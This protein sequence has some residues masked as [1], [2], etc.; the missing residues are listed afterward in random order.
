MEDVRE[1]TKR[2]P[3]VDPVAGDVLAGVNDVRLKVTQVDAGIITFTFDALSDLGDDYRPIEAWR[4][5]AKTATVI[6][7]GDEP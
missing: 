4:R 1:A 7:L 6:T 3:R 5:W 2:D